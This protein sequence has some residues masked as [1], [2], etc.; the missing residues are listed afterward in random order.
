MI[1]SDVTIWSEHTQQHLCSPARVRS[2]CYSLSEHR[3]T[4]KHKSFWD[5]CA[6]SALGNH[7]QGDP[8]P[9]NWLKENT[10]VFF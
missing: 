6:A 8:R 1:G 7:N 2:N 4:Q 10:P 9:F 5:E 3:R